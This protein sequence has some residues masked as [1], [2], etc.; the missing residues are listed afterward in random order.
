MLRLSDWMPMR[1]GVRVSCRAKKPGASTLTMLKPINPIE[2]AISA[3]VDMCTSC[4][5]NLP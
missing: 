3:S 1:T 2:Y 5:S 4:S